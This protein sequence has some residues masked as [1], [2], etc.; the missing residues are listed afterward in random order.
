MK[1]ERSKSRT[2]SEVA[3]KASFPF[4]EGNAASRV[5]LVVSSDGSVKVNKID[6]DNAKNNESYI[7]KGRCIAL[8]AESTDSKQSSKD[9]VKGSSD[10]ESGKPLPSQAVYLTLEKKTGKPVVVCSHNETI[11]VVF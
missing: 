7:S 2:E 10:D 6:P 5:H 4:K 1:V 3:W 11:D 8:K 9:K